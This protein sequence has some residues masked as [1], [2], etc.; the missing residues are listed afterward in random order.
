MY[1]ENGVGIRAHG[2]GRG[3]LNIWMKQ[4]MVSGVLDTLSLTFVSCCPAYI[5]FSLSS[6]CL[7]PNDLFY[8]SILAF[9]GDIFGLDRR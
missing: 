7:F 6:S 2:N 8:A 4:G 9:L 3:L 1:D 5:S